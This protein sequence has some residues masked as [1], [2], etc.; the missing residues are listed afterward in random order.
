MSCDVCHVRIQHVSLPNII[1]WYRT[2]NTM[3]STQA[4][5]TEHVKHVDTQHSTTLT[6]H[7]G[8]VV[9]GGRGVEL[10]GVEEKQS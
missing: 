7:R 8:A 5:F 3:N 6:L 10:G 4:R 2:T 9:A 1:F